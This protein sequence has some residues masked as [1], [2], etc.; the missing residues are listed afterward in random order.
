MKQGLNDGMIYF[1]QKEKFAQM[2]RYTDMRD[3]TKY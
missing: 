1:Q 3:S 2:A